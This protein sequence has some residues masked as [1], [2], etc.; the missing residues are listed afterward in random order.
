MCIY[1]CILC[2]VFKIDPFSLPM[3]NVRKATMLKEKLI[4][5]A[6]LDEIADSQRFAPEWKLRNWI[7]LFHV[8]AEALIV[9][10]NVRKDRMGGSITS[11]MSSNDALPVLPSVASSDPNPVQSGDTE[12][13]L[14]E[15]SFQSLI[16]AKFC[17]DL[18][19][20]QTCFDF[21]R[22]VFA[23]GEDIASLEVINTSCAPT[24][25]QDVVFIDVAATDYNYDNDGYFDEQPRG[26]E[27]GRAME[28]E[29]QL[30]IERSAAAAA[31]QR[32]QQQAYD[33]QTS[34]ARRGS[35]G[36]SSSM[37]VLNAGVVTDN[38]S[39]VTNQNHAHDG[40]QKSNKQKHHSQHQHQH[41]HNNHH[42]HHQHHDP[43]HDH[44]QKH[45]QPHDHSQR[46]QHQQQH[47]HSS[48]K[49]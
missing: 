44:D 40:S 2:I 18:I 4:D 49:V 43:H 41:H 20:D 17:S 9:V 45:E 35:L 42:E 21:W 16:R 1:L 38:R 46:S 25:E 24:A 3:R 34:T 19:H 29:I 5:S 12:A 47:H 26:S 22:V 8:L 31:H 7:K 10:Y 6:P 33:Q 36:R 32:Q 27:S 39:A 15:K 23:D 13:T 48:K 28:A 30:G 14:D 11:L 37:P